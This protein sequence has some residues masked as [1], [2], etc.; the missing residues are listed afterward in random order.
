MLK[1]VHPTSEGN[2]KLFFSKSCIEDA[3]FWLP[4]ASFSRTDTDLI[5]ISPEGE[6]V[7]FH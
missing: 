1:V 2:E 7:F 4:K 5:A 6:K 3:P